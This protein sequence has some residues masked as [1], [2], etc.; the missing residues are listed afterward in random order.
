MTLPR[1]DQADCLLTT[2]L[3][4]PTRPVVELQGKL[5]LPTGQANW[6]DLGAIVGEYWN[7]GGFYD[8]TG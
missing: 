1:A 6:G 3:V 2:A 5:V 4:Y 7:P 8:A